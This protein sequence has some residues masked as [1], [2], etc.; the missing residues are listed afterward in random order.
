MTFSLNQVGFRV[1]SRSGALLFSV[2]MERMGRSCDL[3]PLT[4]SRPLEED[5]P[6]GRQVGVRKRFEVMWGHC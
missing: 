6:R 3:A 4:V 5:S 1:S 2:Q